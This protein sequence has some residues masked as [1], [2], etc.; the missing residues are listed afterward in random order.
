MIKEEFIVYHLVTREKMNV[1]QKI[2]F[3]NHQKNQLYHFFFEREQLNGIGQDAVQIIY[4][5]KENN[6]IKLNEDDTKV[7]L[8][9]VDQTTRAIRETIT[10]MV[11]LEKYPEYPSRLSCL[12]ATKNYEDAMRWKQLFDSFNRQVLQLVKLKVKG[13]CFEGDGNLLPKEDGLSFSKK[14]E[15]AN[16]YWQG[17]ETC[18]LPEL[19]V[20]GKIEVIEIVEDYLEGEN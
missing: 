2:S 11:R 13:A 3:D 15:Q 12:Y 9:Y 7:T 5:S 16:S 6:E 17:S 10:E 20:N 18:E 14:I 4:S 19:L 1:G 8:S